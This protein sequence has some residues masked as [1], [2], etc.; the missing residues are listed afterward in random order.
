MFAP[1]GTPDDRVQHL[2]K[3]F[4]ALAEDDGFKTLMKRINADLH[5]LDQPEFS[6]MLQADSKAVQN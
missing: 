4:N 1:A 5:Y 3:T 2:R 6:E